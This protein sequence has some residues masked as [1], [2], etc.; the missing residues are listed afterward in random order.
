MTKNCFYK[1]R[2]KSAK[3]Q[4][5]CAST[6]EVDMN[7]WILISPIHNMSQK[8]SFVLTIPNTNFYKIGHTVFKR[9]KDGDKYVTSRKQ[10][11]VK[12]IHK[13]YN[14]KGLRNIK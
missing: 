13:K 10:T 14:K 11:I 6:Y 1:E 3:Y 9:Q 7:T 4:T 8:P 5:I 2:G 12:M